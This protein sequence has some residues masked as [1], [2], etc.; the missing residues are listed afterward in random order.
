[1]KLL[2]GLF[3]ILIVIGFS[4]NEPTKMAKSNELISINKN[5]EANFDKDF[6]YAESNLEI[7]QTSKIKKTE[8]VD[9]YTESTNTSKQ[10]YTNKK[11]INKLADKDNDE[12]SG[13]ERALVIVY[14]SLTI[15]LII[16]CLLFINSKL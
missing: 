16:L 3:Y 4:L 8:I 13:G 11:N 14:Y 5:V 15:L 2:I 10:I 6:F 9:L 1:M 12:I 7:D